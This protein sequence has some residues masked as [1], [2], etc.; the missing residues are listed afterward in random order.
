MKKKSQSEKAKTFYHLNKIRRIKIWYIVWISFGVLSLALI[1]MRL[2]DGLIHST[3]VSSIAPLAINITSFVLSY[4]NIKM[5][6]VKM[7][8]CRFIKLSKEG[9]HLYN[10]VDGREQEMIKW[11]NISYVRLAAHEKGCDR[12]HIGIIHP[13][14][15]KKYKSK[16]N[17][18]NKEMNFVIPIVHNLGYNNKSQSEEILNMCDEY[19]CDYIDS[20]KTDETA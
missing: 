4:I 5:E 15:L 2:I 17:P 3:R 12:Y 14:L 8:K 20:K 9:L 16:A 19:L 10:T 7:E 11:D 18:F 13:V 6:K 1:A